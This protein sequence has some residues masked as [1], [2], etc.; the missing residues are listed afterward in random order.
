MDLGEG[1]PDNERTMNDIVNLANQIQPNIVMTGDCP[2]KHATGRVPMLDLAI[3]M[4][5]V[6]M[7]VNTDIGLFRLAVEQVSYGFYKK[8]MSS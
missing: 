5:E 8:P 3:Y 4:E 7:K 2:S 6:D 1:L